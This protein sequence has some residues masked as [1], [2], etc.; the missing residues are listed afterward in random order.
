[1]PISH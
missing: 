1:M